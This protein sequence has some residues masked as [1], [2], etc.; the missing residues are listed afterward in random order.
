M[1]GIGI[2]GELFVI[3]S[4]YISRAIKTI[5]SGNLFS[6]EKS[7]FYL[8]KEDDAEDLFLVENP[9]CNE[10]IDVIETPNGVFAIDKHGIY[11]ILDSKELHC[12]I[13]TEDSFISSIPD[14]DL[15]NVY[16]IFVSKNKDKYSFYKTNY[17]T[18]NIPRTHIKYKYID[19][20]N[21]LYQKYDEEKSVNDYN[22]ELPI[23]KFN[24]ILYVNFIDHLSSIYN[25]EKFNNIRYIDNKTY[26]DV[27]I[28]PAVDRN[29]TQILNNGTTV[30]K[31]GTFINKKFVLSTNK[32]GFK[33]YKD[34][35]K[36]DDNARISDI[37]ELKRYVIRNKKDSGKDI[38]LV[39]KNIIK[40]LSD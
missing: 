15:N 26:G 35:I 31:I 5:P 8:E 17:N 40:L 38:S 7:M 3:D 22:D 9:Y 13:Y 1:F 21:D 25:T 19:L 24:S 23:I 14:A 10:V 4:S 33:K 36:V 12:L 30:N 39:S 28:G 18:K 32:Y 11:E 6:D 20:F 27:K 34:I 37:N 29:F 16:G 2:N